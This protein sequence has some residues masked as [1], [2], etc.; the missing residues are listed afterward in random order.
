[1]ANINSSEF[2]ELRGDRM[3][4]DIGPECPDCK[5]N[6]WYSGPGMWIY[7]VPSDSDF[8]L[9][10]KARDGMA[11]AQAQCACCHRVENFDVREI[12]CDTI[13]RLRS[14]HALQRDQYN[15]IFSVTK[16]RN[17]L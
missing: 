13:Q 14:R 2:A 6:G 5:D 11:V 1:M 12:H 8:E 16:G 10:I 17:R 7:G 15:G 9:A 3:I 4:T